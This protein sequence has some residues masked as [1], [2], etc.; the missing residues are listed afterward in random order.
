MV[1]CRVPNN[2]P[3]KLGLLSNCCSR[4]ENSPPKLGGVPSPN[5]VRREAGWFPAK[6][7]KVRALEPPRPLAMVAGT[8]P[9]L[10]WELSSHTATVGN[11]PSDEGESKSILP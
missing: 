2:S 7:R 8:P 5:E 9:N 10:G 11:R 3:P 4:E 1:D 6:R